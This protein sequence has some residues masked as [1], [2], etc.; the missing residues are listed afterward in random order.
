MRLTLTA[1]GGMKDTLG[2]RTHR[3]DAK[4]GATV[5]DVLALLCAEHPDVESALAT[6]AIAVGDELVSRDFAL[7]EGDE[8]G[9]LPPVS[10]G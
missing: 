9:L 8:V 1:F 5:S 2:A 6:L 4:E 7:R 10:G 3:L